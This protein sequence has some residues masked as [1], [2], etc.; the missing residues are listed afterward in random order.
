LY[1]NGLMMIT[2]RIN[3]LI[4][5]GGV[6]IAPDTIEE[7]IKKHAAISDAAAVGV[8]DEVGIEQIWLAI[9]SR[10]GELDVKKVYEYCR[11]HMP[12]FVPDRIFQVK[13]IPRNQLGKVSRVPLTEEL[14][15]LESSHVLAVR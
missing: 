3:E 1:R 4:N 14:K 8:L 6:K 9:V 13:A 2:G 11:E 5:R 12:M 7:E 15:T 10:D